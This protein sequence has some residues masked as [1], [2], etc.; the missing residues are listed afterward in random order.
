MF[1]VRA[2]GPDSEDKD[3]ELKW[4]KQIFEGLRLTFV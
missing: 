4:Q 3:Y 1:T 2:D